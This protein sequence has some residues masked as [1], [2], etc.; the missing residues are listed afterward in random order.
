[1][2]LPSSVLAGCVVRA[3]TGSPGLLFLESTGFVSTAFTDELPASAALLSPACAAAEEL[4]L[5]CALAPERSTSTAPCPDARA[6]A[7]A[8]LCAGGLWAGGF[9]AGAAAIASV[10]ATARNTAEMYRVVM[11]HT[12]LWLPTF[13]QLAAVQAERPDALRREFFPSGHSQS[14]AR[15]RRGSGPGD[16]ILPPGPA[17]R[18]VTSGCSGGAQPTGDRALT[19]FSVP[20]GTLHGESGQALRRVRYPI[21]PSLS[22]RRIDFPVDCLSIESLKLIMA[23][24]DSYMRRIAFP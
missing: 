24:I 4:A 21:G 1:M 15:S 16:R 22:R 18:H 17:G 3:L 8:W 13:S 23:W 12:L 9:W 7:P 19:P 20:R 5:S 14:I 6:E 11:A 2:D 10:V